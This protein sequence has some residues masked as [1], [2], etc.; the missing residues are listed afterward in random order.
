[1]FPVIHA[2]FVSI[3][4]DWKSLH[5]LKSSGIFAFANHQQVQLLT[6]VHI[7]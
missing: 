5:I 3:V 4:L 1:M 6:S 2:F 7:A